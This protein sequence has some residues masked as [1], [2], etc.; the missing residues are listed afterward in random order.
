ML[1]VSRKGASHALYLAFVSAAARA[2]GFLIPLLIATVYGAGP[3]T[4]A[5]FLFYSAVLLLGGTVGQTVE[6]STAPF[7][8]RALRDTGGGLHTFLRRAAGNA[9]VAGII[10]WA[11]AIPVLLLTAPA[12]LRQQLPLYAAVFAPLAVLWC[13][14]GPYSGALI[15]QGRIALATGSMVWRG[16]GALVGLAMAPLG[17]GLATVG[18]GLGFG[19][20]ARLLWLRRRLAEGMPPPSPYALSLAPWRKSTAAQLMAGVATSSAPLAERLLAGSLGSGVISHLEYSMRLLGI[21]ILL[22][23]GALAPLL[24]TRWTNQ[25]AVRG[26]T[27]SRRDT[28]SPV[29]KGVALAAACAALLV[30]FSPTVVTLVLR[31]GR[32]T[33]TDAVA[34]AGLL[35]ILGV[36]F[37]AS[38]GALLLERL[39][40][41]GARNRT[42]AAFSV[43][44]VGMRIG[45][46]AL[47][48]HTHGLVAFGVGYAVAETVYLLTLVAFANPKERSGAPAPG[49]AGG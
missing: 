39:Y 4:D 41:A 35:R 14:T 1:G 23:D 24:L 7:A 34:V 22:F 46:A 11:C 12:G 13:M 30:A 16:T 8:A 43:M 18:L 32:F 40:L 48:L 47:L 31:H 25:I 37:V 42:L 36:G 10:A 15:S 27:P 44:R 17:A 38:M 5:Y 45:I 3:R 29:L 2:P 20:L 26:N 49:T 21:P 6:V 9:A 19:E 33:N 28:L